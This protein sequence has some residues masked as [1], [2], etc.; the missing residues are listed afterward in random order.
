MDRN[1]DVT[2]SVTD[3]NLR[4]TLDKLIKNNFSKRVYITPNIP[5]KQLRNAIASMAI[6]E[7]SN[8]LALVDDSFTRS[9]KAGI[10][11]DSDGIYWKKYGVKRSVKFDSVKQ[12]DMKLGF[13][14]N[15]KI[16]GQEI[17]LDHFSKEEIQ[18]FADFLLDILG[19]GQVPVGAAEKKDVQAQFESLIESLEKSKY[20]W[21][22]GTIEKLGKLGDERAVV[23]IIKVLEEGSIG[24]RKSAA[25]ALGRIGGEKAR[26]A[27]IKC[28]DSGGDGEVLISVCFALGQI[29]G[30]RAK[31]A[32]NRARK[33]LENDLIGKR[34]I[35]GFLE[36]S[37]KD[38]AENNYRKAQKRADD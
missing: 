8:V 18:P 5:E 6:P 24:D 25:I 37:V 3:Q 30:R 12:F 16:N 28:L 29:G 13:L 33:K 27:L 17:S 4:N 32:L 26:D 35:F 20:H 2:K 10:C 31:E 15:F 1:S 36:P 7:G 38:A 21:C 34:N 11:V 22:S 14:I 19:F 9:G 23:P